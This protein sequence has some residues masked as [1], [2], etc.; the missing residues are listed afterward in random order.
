MRSG[1]WVWGLFAVLGL[2]LAVLP[3]AAA[4][5]YP[6][7]PI[8]NIYPFSPGGFGDIVLRAISAE[9]TKSLGQPVVV[10]NRAGA[11]TMIG[12]D[13]CA[14]A[15]PDGH[16]L[17]MLTVD[18]LSYNP[19]LYKK[20]LYDAANDFEPIINLVYLTEG[21][22]VNPALKVNNLAEL[23][24]L[25][26]STPGSLNYGTPA[27]NVMLFMEAFKRDT[28]TDI[29]MIPY[30]GPGDAVNALVAGEVQV[31][32]IGIGNVIGHIRGG[33]IKPLA[34]DGTARSPLFPDVPT[35][36]ESGYRGVVNRIW[37][38]ILGPAGMPKPVVAR[39]NSEIS[40]IVSVPAFKEQY[41]TALGLEAILDSPEHFAQFI[42]E[43]RARGEDLVRQSG[44]RPE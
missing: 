16:T 35:L 4:Q 22:L 40:R 1:S 42:R 12:A 24:A 9:L 2:Q 29:K 17:C 15:P 30:K 41:I 34:V 6:T 11:N 8:R 36:A 37:L 14:K 39:L 23:I 33:R 5:Q 3:D 32:F 38:G 21:L 19:F 10:E 26:K 43:N 44:L 20:P 18:T 13:A 27:N 31:G 28:G 25:A 7:R